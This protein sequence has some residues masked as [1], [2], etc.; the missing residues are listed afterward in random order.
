MDI[1][2]KNTSFDNVKTLDIYKSFIWTDRYYECGDFELY[3]SVNNSALPYLLDDYYLEIDGSEHLMVI[4]DFETTTDV[5]DGNYIIVT[6]RS[7]ES[8]LDRRIVW[9]HTS[10]KGSLSESIKKLLNEN[11]ISPSD[12]NRKIPNLIFKEPIDQRILDIEVDTQFYGETLLDAISSTCK[13][14]DVGFK[15]TLSDSNEL[16]FELYMGTDRSYEQTEVPYIEFSPSFDNILNTNFIQ[17]TKSLKN[18]ALV[19]GEGEGANRKVV[20][21]QRDKAIYAGLAR[22]EVFIDAYDISSYTTGGTISTADYNAQLTQ[23][24]LDELAD[25]IKTE[26]FDGEVLS[27]GIYQ[28]GID[29]FMGD[30]VQL[31][32][33]NDKESRSRVTEYIISESTSESTAYPTFTKV[34]EKIEEEVIVYGYN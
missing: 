2:I 19:G 21:V 26:S 11:A 28:Y 34:E 17:S 32:D 27:N 12:E 24:G 16:V 14:F 8:I 33:Q 31:V 29:Y 30:I 10:L 7:L 5:E 4:E 1:T 18:I 13:S 20:T 23:R 3:I 25:Y 9:S 6:G 22:R 15:I